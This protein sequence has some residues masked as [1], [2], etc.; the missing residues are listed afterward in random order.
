M[1]TERD[2]CMTHTNK[3]KH[4]FRWKVWETYVQR[5]TLMISFDEKGAKMIIVSLDLTIANASFTSSWW[6]WWNKNSVF[7]VVF[8][9]VDPAAHP[10]SLCVVFLPE[11]RSMSWGTG[12]T[13]CARKQAKWSQSTKTNYIVVQICVERD[14]GKWFRRNKIKS[15]ELRDTKENRVLVKEASDDKYCATCC[16]WW[17]TARGGETGNKKNTTRNTYTG[18][19]WWWW[20]GKTSQGWSDTACYEWTWNRRDSRSFIHQQ[21]QQQQQK[22]AGSEKWA[23]NKFH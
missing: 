3:H 18:W 7:L 4:L 16:Y 2:L 10:V 13:F 8:S 23:K 14:V 22:K 5:L 9:K 15:T 21:Q 1:G 20:S 19:W 11:T 17:E 12:C 6:V